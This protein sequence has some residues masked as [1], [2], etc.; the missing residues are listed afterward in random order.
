[1]KKMSLLIIFGLLLLSGQLAFAYYDLGI[2]YELRQNYLEDKNLGT[3]SVL[4]NTLTAWEKNQPVIAVRYSIAKNSEKSAAFLPLIKKQFDF[5]AGLK[6]NKDYLL[7]FATTQLIEDNA[8]KNDFSAYGFYLNRYGNFFKKTEIA[9]ESDNSGKSL[10][11]GY[12]RLAFIGDTDILTGF[13]TESSNDKT[14]QRFGLAIAPHLKSYSMIF[15]LT[16]N[17]KDS[18]NA[19]LYGLSYSGVENSKFP[20]FITVFRDK[21]ASRYFLGIMAF[22]SKALNQR[23]YQ[24][25][26]DAMFSGTLS[27]TRVIANRNFDQIGVSNLYKTRDYGKLVITASIGDIKISDANSLFFDAE[28]TIYTFIGNGNSVKSWSMSFGH[29]GETNLIF[30]PT[31]RNLKEDYQQELTFGIGAKFSAQEQVFDFNLVNSYNLNQS[32]WSGVSIMTNFYF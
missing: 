27:G 32:K 13:S 3:S 25:I 26:Y 9:L 30:N 20:N 24:G 7:K 11:Y 2:Q 12:G 28:E 21:P 5:G 4:S 29:N 23:A 16:R 6:L 31:T 17:L 22:G 1:M 15:G 14:E 10:Y 19:K 18:D 8:T